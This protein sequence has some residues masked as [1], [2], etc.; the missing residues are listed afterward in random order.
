MTTR[1]AV[2]GIGLL[3]AVG[4]TRDESWSN[5]VDGRC[6][7]GPLTLFES[8]GYRSRIAAQ[9]DA[10]AIR[11]R[12]TPLQRRRWSRS[13]QFAVLSAQEAIADAG[14]TDAYHWN[15]DRVGIIIGS[16]TGDLIRNERYVKGTVLPGSG[17]R[18]LSDAW[19]HFYSTC[20]DIIAAEFGFEGLRSC[21]VAAC[22]SSTMAVGSAL[23]A[24]RLGRADAVLA[25]GTDSLARL[26]FSGFNALRVMDPEACR[27]F[28]RGRAGMNI[29]EGA[30]MLVLEKMDAARRRGARIY[31]EVVGH[32][33]TCEA[34]HPTSPEP[35]GRAIAATM[36]RAL[37][38]AQVPASDVRHVNAHGTATPHN[39]RAESRGIRMV[40]GEAARRL[41]VTS[42]KSMVGHTLGASG[43][44][45]A[46]VA[47]LTVFH[48]VIPPTIHH[49]ETDPECEVDVVAND[50][51]EMRVDCVVSTSLAFGG[52]D[53]AVVLRAV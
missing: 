27:P 34:F 7:I 38:D 47:A 14:L 40:F 44:I 41:P 16:S 10:A 49:T 11:D 9:V 30:A 2:T 37:G 21:I 32:S 46:A 26:T 39:D 43:G 29:G 35:D 50:A 4:T 23:D 48:G 53:A 8:D 42:V 20:V 31:A 3:T 13:D 15:P 5:L 52:N 18:R 6:G 1:I 22:A 25:G 28:D 45:E 19:N 33:L 17:P 24:I 36:S 12:L 51:R